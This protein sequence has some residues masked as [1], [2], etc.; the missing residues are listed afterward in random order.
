MPEMR[1]EIHADTPSWNSEQ[2]RLLGQLVTHHMFDFE[3][4]AKELQQSF[5]PPNVAHL[6][7]ATACRLQFAAQHRQKEKKEDSVDGEN[8]DQDGIQV[9]NN[10]DTQQ[11][12]P[13][14]SPSQDQHEQQNGP[15]E[16][17]ADKTAAEQDVKCLQ[18]KRQDIQRRVDAS[19]QEQA[20]TETQ[21]TK[22]P[23]FDYSR[24]TALAA[25]MGK[26]EQREF[27]RKAA[28][29]AAKATADIDREM[30]TERAARLKHRDEWKLKIEK[31]READAEALEAM[32]QEQTKAAAEAEAKL[33]K[34]TPDE[35]ARHDRVQVRN[36]LFVFNSI[37][38]GLQNNDS[39]AEYK[40]TCV[41]PCCVATGIAEAVPSTAVWWVYPRGPGYFPPEAHRDCRSVCG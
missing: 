11:A 17:N 5:M 16:N 24:F 19:R 3:L 12:T 10:R 38:V 9:S 15:L 36:R 8:E 6:Y 33:A 20:K 22:A 29:A 30:A 40:Y 27:A 2:R 4:V 18:K 39:N 32:K 34:M 25:Q 23:A 14:K 26:E 28:Q 31:Q 7:D 1:N 21:V 35:R 13:N 41:R 37:C